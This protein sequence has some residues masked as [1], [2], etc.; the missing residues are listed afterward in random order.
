MYAIVDVYL[1]LFRQESILCR[2]A[3]RKEAC[4]FI[5]FGSIDNIFDLLHL[6]SCGNMDHNPKTSMTITFLSI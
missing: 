4:E 2:K 1:P 5:A 3:Y 6:V